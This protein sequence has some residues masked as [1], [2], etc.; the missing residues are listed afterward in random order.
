MADNK[1]KNNV[2]DPTE[3]AL[4]VLEGSLGSLYSKPAA[5]VFCEAFRG[6]SEKFGSLGPKDVA[7]A[8]KWMLEMARKKC[9]SLVPEMEDED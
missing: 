1:P 8:E 9:L 7:L 2:D 3:R 5:K 4:L 6:M